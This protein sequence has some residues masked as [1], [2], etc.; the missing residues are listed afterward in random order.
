MFPVWVPIVQLQSL[1]WERGKDDSNAV[2]FFLI[3]VVK[4]WGP[5]QIVG[6]GTKNQT[7]IL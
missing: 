4:I 2:V 1:V 3:Q 5:A 6:K 7:L